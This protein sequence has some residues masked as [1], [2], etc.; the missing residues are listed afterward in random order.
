MASN[1]VFLTDPVV[2]LQLAALF[3]KVQS[4][5][6]EVGAGKGALSKL[7]PAGS[8]CVQLD[9]AFEKDLKKIKHIQPLIGDFLKL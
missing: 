8:T 9:P 2:L 7:L 5:V 3:S 6:V 1:Q 4:P